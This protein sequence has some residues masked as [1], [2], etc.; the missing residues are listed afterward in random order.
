VKVGS[1][2]SGC[3]G[4]ALGYEWAGYEHKWFVEKEEYAK[5]IL[6]KRFPKATVYGDITEVDFTTVPKVDVLE[7]GFPCQDISNAGKRAGIEGSR[8]SLWKHFLRAIS[9]IRPKYVSIENV[10]ALRGRGLDVVLCDLA[11]LGYDAEWHCISASAVGAPHRRDRIF[12]IAYPSSGRRDGEQRKESVCE[13]RRVEELGDTNS[14]G[15]Q[16]HLQ[17]GQ[18]GRDERRHPLTD[19]SIPR[20]EDVP[21][22]ESVRFGRRDMRTDTR[23]EP[24]DKQERDKGR[25]EVIKP[26]WGI[27]AESGICRVSDGVPNRVDRIRCLG[28]AVVPQCAEVFAEAIKEELIKDE[29]QNRA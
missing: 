9:E 14:S 29:R 1:L 26:V 7:G 20:G 12:I 21:D 16:G 8:S 22:T 13:E 19:T 24:E 11:S 6:R 5:T 25:D 18:R 23:H 17:L 15:L 10:A 4:T 3:G 27:E 28:N 2:F